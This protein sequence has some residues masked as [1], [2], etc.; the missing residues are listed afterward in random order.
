[1]T[2]KQGEDTAQA[3]WDWVQWARRCR[4]EPFVKLQRSIVKHWDAI[5]AA[6]KQRPGREHEH[7]DPTDHPHGLRLQ[8]RQGPHRP[9]HAQPRRIPPPTTGPSH[10]ITPP[11][12]A[13]EEPHFSLVLLACGVSSGTPRWP[14][15][16]ALAI[17]P[18]PSSRRGSTPRSSTSWVRTQRPLTSRFVLLAGRVSRGRRAAVR[19]RRRCACRC[20]PAEGVSCGG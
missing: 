4:L 14:S 16:R 2:L 8:G 12:E 11:T 7:Q 10:R 5:T 15:S 19:V 13:T 9:R 17:C 3:L 20:C 6:G 1:M 18:A